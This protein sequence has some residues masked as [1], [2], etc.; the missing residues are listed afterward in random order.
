MFPY[1]G[2]ESRHVYRLHDDRDWLDADEAQQLAALLDRFWALG[3]L[4]GR[5]RH[6]LWTT[7][8]VAWEYYLDIVLPALVSALEGLVNTDKNSVMKQFTTRVP[9]LARE[10]DVEGVSKNFCRKMYEARSQGA[11]GSDIDMFAAG[12][13]R[14]AA[15]AKVARLQAVLR[16]AVRRGI[17]DPEFR[18]VF[19]DDASIK[20][21]WPVL[22]RQTRWRWRRRSVVTRWPTIPTTRA[23]PADNPSRHTVA[24]VHF[25]PRQMAC[26]VAVSSPEVPRSRGR[27]RLGWPPAQRSGRHAGLSDGPRPA[28][29]LVLRRL[30]SSL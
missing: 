2:W 11:H 27:R 17:E 14:P 24:R 5:L 23:P 4:H 8:H 15:V 29:Q 9:L 6:A 16:R 26:G 3:E 25:T 12:A 21:R 1:D 28:S 22:V 19:D 18:A 13:D 20:A 7:E 30:S 10:L